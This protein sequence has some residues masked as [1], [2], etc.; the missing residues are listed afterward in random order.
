MLE[1]CIDYAGLFPPAGLDMESSV[2]NYAHYHCDELGWALGRF[3]L[4][5]SLLEEFNFSVDVIGEDE[6]TTE[7][8]RLS[9]L[10]GEDL[11]DSIDR[12]SRFNKWHEERREIAAAVIDTIEVKT[13]T[14]ETIE[15]AADVIPDSMTLFCEVPIGLELDELL[16]EVVRVGGCAKVRTGGVLPELIPSVSEVAGFL[17]ACRRS[18]VPFKATAG[19]HHPLRSERP[20]TYEPGSP[21]GVMHGFINVL[22]AAAFSYNGVEEGVIVDLLSEESPDTFRFEENTVSWREHRMTTEALAKAR[23]EFAISF[24]S[25]AFDEPFEDLKGLNLI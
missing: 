24:G 16:A 5:V 15:R 7:T 20:L 9:I 25:C 23:T 14:T 6:D 3:I 22:L 11:E 19:L 12:V 21:K 10:A 8:W 13:P 18:A 1:G 4:P 17:M 2:R